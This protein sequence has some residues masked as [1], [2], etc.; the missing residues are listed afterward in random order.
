MPK[1]DVDVTRVVKIGRLVDRTNLR[2]ATRDALKAAS[3]TTDKASK[4]S[5]LG[6]GVQSFARTTQDAVDR[7]YPDGFWFRVFESAEERRNRQ[8]AE[9][10]A[11]GIGLLASLLKR[12]G[13]KDGS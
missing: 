1:F 2:G 12:N 5:R 7:N 11:A 3:G 13:T 9:I 8:N 10:F 6:S 4:L